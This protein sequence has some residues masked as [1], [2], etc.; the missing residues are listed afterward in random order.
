MMEKTRHQEIE[1][2]I[3]EVADA[4]PVG[5]FYPDMRELAESLLED[6]FSREELL[7]AFEHVRSELR[8]R[9]RED[10]EDELL[11]VM[12]DLEGWSAPH[13]RI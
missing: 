5:A 2:Q 1:R 13:S 4:S 7:E 10:Q 8:E 9:G 12:D 3:L 6:G 11:E